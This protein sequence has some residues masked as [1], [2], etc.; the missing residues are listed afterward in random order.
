MK[1]RLVALG[2]NHD[3]QTNDKGLNECICLCCS[4][5]RRKSRKNVLC[6]HL[7]RWRRLHHHHQLNPSIFGERESKVKIYQTSLLTTHLI[8]KDFSA[9]VVSL[10]IL[11]VWT[12][13]LRLVNRHDLILLPQSFYFHPTLSSLPS[14]WNSVYLPFRAFPKNLLHF[15]FRHARCFQMVHPQ[16]DCMR[17]MVVPLQYEHKFHEALPMLFPKHLPTTHHLCYSQKQVFRFCKVDN[18]RQ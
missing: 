2:M 9:G 15:L 16:D 8:P 1:R 5:H 13:E 7:S 12:R 14:L 3:H 10:P 6:S 11:D 17:S 4:R 18:H